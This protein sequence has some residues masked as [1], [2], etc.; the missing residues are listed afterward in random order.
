MTRVEN[1]NSQRTRVRPVGYVFCPEK[2]VKDLGLRESKVDGGHLV[3]AS[4]PRSAT[5]RTPRPVVSVDRA[6]QSRSSKER[7]RQARLNH[8]LDQIKWI[9]R[10]KRW[11][12]GALGEM[13]PQH[14]GIKTGSPRRTHAAGT[15]STRGGRDRTE[16]RDKYRRTTP[17]PRSS[18]EI[19]KKTG[20]PEH[21]GPPR[22]STIIAS[23]NVSTEKQIRTIVATRNRVQ[24][25]CSPRCS[26]NENDQ[27]LSC[28][29]VSGSCKRDSSELQQ[30]LRE[31]DEQVQEDIKHSC[32]VKAQVFDMNMGDDDHIDT[33][34][35]KSLAA[36]DQEQADHNTVPVLVPTIRASEN[37]DV[38]RDTS[39][40]SRSRAPQQRPAEIQVVPAT[41]GTV[42]PNILYFSSARLDEGEDYF[43][44]NS[45]STFSAQLLVSN[46]RKE[47]K[48]ST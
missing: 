9:G 40:R 44:R 13:Q 35:K 24:E 36:V 22:S 23:T 25:N 28:V 7:V 3:A 11:L 6:S 2:Q 38:D 33:Q 19:K 18:G 27:G 16:D 4:C 43:T 32:P 8:D 37:D 45:S 1:Q 14:Q 12:S 5:P 42:I 26:T 41:T 21:R 39:A 15:T 17:R 47:S 20:A 31:E 30:K 46:A 29:S 34:S 48:S 10:Q